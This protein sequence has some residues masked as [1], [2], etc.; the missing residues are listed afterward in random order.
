MV[1]RNCKKT[2]DLF[3]KLTYHYWNGPSIVDY[4]I[5]PTSELYSISSLVVGYLISWIS[6][7]CIIKT[8]VILKNKHSEKV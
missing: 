8:K 2:G 3:G 4:F 6:D 1:I 5:L 7:H